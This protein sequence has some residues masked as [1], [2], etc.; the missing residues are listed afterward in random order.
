MEKERWVSGEGGRRVAAEG[1]GVVDV[2]VG[3]EVE[4]VGFADFEE[5]GL[6]LG[7]VVVD[8]DGG[9]GGRDDIVML[10]FRERLLLLVFFCCLC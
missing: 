7:V 8:V 3:F 10:G 9:G 5:E 1:F 6:G 4:G 2:D